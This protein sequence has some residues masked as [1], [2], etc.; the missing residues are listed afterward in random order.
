MGHRGHE[1]G[2]GALSPDDFLSMNQSA[3]MPDRRGEI[4]SYR[5]GLMEAVGTL[6]LGALEES[7]QRFSYARLILDDPD[8]V[9][10]PGH[11]GVGH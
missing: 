2:A 1:P 8:S 7:N 9:T 10:A 6:E 3:E 11:A 5:P 4:V